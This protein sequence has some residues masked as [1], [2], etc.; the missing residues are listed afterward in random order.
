MDF[1]HH[2]LSSVTKTLLVRSLVMLCENM[3]MTKVVLE[4]INVSMHAAS[5]KERHMTPQRISRSNIRVSLYVFNITETQRHHL[6]DIYDF[7]VR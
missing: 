5:S 6:M 3:G 7:H 4:R 1:L 2:S